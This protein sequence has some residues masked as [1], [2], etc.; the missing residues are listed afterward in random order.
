[1]IMEFKSVLCQSF[2]CIQISQDKEQ[3]Q[4]VLTQEFGI[5]T[6]LQAV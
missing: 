4:A 6:G 3:W 2:N 1:M 5:E